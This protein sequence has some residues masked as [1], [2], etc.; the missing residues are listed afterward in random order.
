MLDIQRFALIIGAMKSGTT[1]LFSLLDQHPEINGCKKK[2]PG[3]FVWNNYT[4]KKLE[5]YF[6]LWDFTSDQ[7][8]IAIEA[9][10]SY[11]K[12]PTHRNVPQLIKKSGIDARF[13]YM[14][15]HPIHR[16]ESHLKMASGIGYRIFG[17]N[18]QLFFPQSYSLYHRQLSA[19]YKL[20][21]AENILLLRFED[22][23][24]DPAKTLEQ[25]CSFL[26]IDTEFTFDVSKM[27]KHESK[28]YIQ[29][30]SINTKAK[31]MAQPFK[32]QL[33]R[34]FSGE[35]AHRFENPNI[36]PT[37]E[38]YTIDNVLTPDQK[39]AMYKEIRNDMELL[40]QDFGFDTSQWKF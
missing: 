40:Q 39:A 1:A 26:E 32:D 7:Q 8:K 20:F 2:E 14:M 17:K 30:K 28:Q 19:Y 33:K 36:K 31:E 18:G 27:V 15:R 11:S 23:T 4:T 5:D 16:I 35:K 3:F 6:N 38:V 24:S 10:T 9:S 25:I 21:P 37:A 12:L 34:S 13:I 22:F 29:R